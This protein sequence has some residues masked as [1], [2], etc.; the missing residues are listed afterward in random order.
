MIFQSENVNEKLSA[1][2]KT[3]FA[4]LKSIV[5]VDELDRIFKTRG[6]EHR[7]LELTTLM[8]I[9]FRRRFDRSYEK[10][11]VYEIREFLF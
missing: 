5:N 1:T 2:A 8:A 11:Q 4:T 7:T 3:I 9:S 6:E 10:E